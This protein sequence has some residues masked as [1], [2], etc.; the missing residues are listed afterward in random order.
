MAEINLFHVLGE[1]FTNS[2]T[3]EER[4]QIDGISTRL[5]NDPNFKG[6]D[7]HE[8]D[9][10]FIKERLARLNKENEDNE[11]YAQM[12]ESSFK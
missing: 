7:Y 9:N 11:R 2:L 4:R 10:S 12:M 6:L 3:Q 5:S 8:Q 1:H